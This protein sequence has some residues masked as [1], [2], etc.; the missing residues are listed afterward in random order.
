MA[1]TVTDR[2]WPVASRNDR[3]VAAGTA[4][5]GAEINTSRLGGIRR[6]QR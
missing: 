4:V 3:L 2:S 5:H 1:L 6:W